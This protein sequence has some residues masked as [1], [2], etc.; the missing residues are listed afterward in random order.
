LY[1]L[2]KKMSQKR[3]NNFLLF[4]FIFFSF[5]VAFSQQ[6][7]VNVPSSEVTDSH[8]VF[9]QQQLNIGKQLQFNSTLDFGLGKGFE[10]GCNLLGLNYPSTASSSGPLIMLNGLKQFKITKSSSLNFG[11]QFGTN[12]TKHISNIHGA[13]ILYMNYRIKDLLVKESN[14]VL[15]TYYHSYHYGGIGNRTGFWIGLEI[16]ITHNFHLM[17]EDII[18]NTDIAASCLGMIYYPID[19]MPLTFGWQFNHNQVSQSSFVF[20]L[21]ITP[22]HHK[23]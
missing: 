11:A 13:N 16:P 8:K 19:W 21:T 23:K 2:L 10:V 14:L 22:K 6:N 4:H 9:F 7:F 20:E 15:G 3:K 1:E 18:G 5:S 17:A 12:A